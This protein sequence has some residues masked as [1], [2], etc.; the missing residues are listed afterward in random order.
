MTDSSVVG[1]LIN[2]RGLVYA[3]LNEQGVV[4]LFGKV[5][6]Q[7]NMYVEEIK[8]GFPDC[9][10]RRFIGRGWERIRIEFEYRSANF[11]EH[12]HDPKQCDMLVC[13]EHN[14]ADCPLEVLELKSEIK[15]LP[16]PP[17]TGPVP[18]EPTEKKTKDKIE[19]IVRRVEAGPN[20]GKWFT[21]VFDAL[22]GV[23]DSIWANPGEIYIGIYCPEKSFASVKLRKTSIQ[24]EC[25]SGDTPI[26]GARISNARFSPRW[27]KF[28]VKT[29]AEAR[30]AISKLTE[31]Y[32]RI[33]EAIKK[34]ELTA[35][36]S[37]GEGLRTA[38]SDKVEE[39]D[40]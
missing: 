34:G 1:D 19:T 31:S 25:F 40:S 7:L 36:F 12:G 13:W 28:S 29:D 10:G 26:E 15:G 3:P 6:D 8:P 2:F 14:W 39:E 22:R 4:F 21:E 37:G 9:I 30:A 17:L 33:K 23:D 11:Q 35:Y 32:R 18:V 20:I 38:G 5:T 27:S 24:F 16:N